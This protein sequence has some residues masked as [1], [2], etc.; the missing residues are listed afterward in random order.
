MLVS[1]GL[2]VIDVVEGT[3]L[4]SLS[5]MQTFL[6]HGEIF[7]T[8]ISRGYKEM[9]SIVTDQELPRINESKCG[10]IG[11]FRA[12]ASEYSCAHGVQINFGD[13]TPYLTYGLFYF[14]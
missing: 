6:R 11:G 12:S 7:L 3:A 9:S 10:G 2:V 4:E 5:H 8:V 1:A 13:L 14:L